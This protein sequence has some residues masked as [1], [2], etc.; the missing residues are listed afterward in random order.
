M[1]NW[2]NQRMIFKQNNEE[3]ENKVLKLQAQID[4]DLPATENLKSNNKKLIKEN[5]NLKTKIT[6]LEEEIEL[7]RETEDTLR[8]QLTL[9]QQN[10]PQDSENDFSEPK[11]EELA[12]RIQELLE[13]I[14]ELQ[15]EKIEVS[16]K[17][18][19]TENELQSAQNRITDLL[20]NNPSSKIV[21]SSRESD[22][23]KEYLERMDTIERRVDQIKTLIGTMKVE[24]FDKI[25]EEYENLH[26]NFIKEAEQK[27]IQKNLEEKGKLAVLK[28]L[29]GSMNESIRVL[30]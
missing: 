26:K 14:E 29:K 11:G 24:S 7:L 20:S 13:E 23:G 19:F 16:E 18:K 22:D 6:S 9:N 28:E 2:S 5:M 27:L 17:L 10:S 12:Q 15:G 30:K 21:E 4:Q 3:L 1:E 25:K 8:D